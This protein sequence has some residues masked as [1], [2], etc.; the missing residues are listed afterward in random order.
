MH[1]AYSASDIPSRMTTLTGLRRQHNEERRSF[2]STRALSW[3]SRRYR[4]SRPFV[5]LSGATTTYQRPG[6]AHPRADGFYVH[7]LVSN[8]AQRNTHKEGPRAKDSLSIVSEFAEERHD[9]AGR[10][11]V[12]ARGGFV[13]EEQQFRLSLPSS[14]KRDMGT[15][16]KNLTLAA[17]STPMVVR[18]L[19]SAPS[20]PTMASA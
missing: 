12:K 5:H 20:E 3:T 1:A 16:L 13:E 18:F 11:R 2:E 7:P 15:M 4:Q 8:S 19:C 9:N 17:S 14:A 6:R 10:L